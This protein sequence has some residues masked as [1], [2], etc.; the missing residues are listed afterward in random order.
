MVDGGDEGE[1]NKWVG[2]YSPMI[3]ESEPWLV[4]IEP[5]T[6]FW[7]TK[8]ARKSMKAFGGRGMYPSDRRLPGGARRLAAGWAGNSDGGKSC[9]EG[10]D[11]SAV[12]SSR[13]SASLNVPGVTLGANVTDRG[14]GEGAP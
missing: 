8:S 6:C 2:R 14:E 7:R 1:A 10:S 11:G 9:V 13:G 5:G 4:S 3:L 12:E